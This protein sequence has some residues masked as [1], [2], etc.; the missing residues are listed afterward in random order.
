MALTSQFKVGAPL[1]A[2]RRNW[3]P[4][5]RLDFGESGLV[6]LD[7]WSGACRHETMAVMRSTFELALAEE[8]EVPFVLYRAGGHPWSD[9]DYSYH[10]A[11]A[12]G[13]PD[14]AADGALAVT[15][16]VVEA[17]SGIVKAVREETC[18][19]ELAEALR[20][21][22]ARDAGRR[23]AER[24]RGEAVGRVHR[25]FP[26][27]EA[28]VAAASIRRVFEPGVGEDEVLETTGRAC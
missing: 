2:G 21:M 24:E 17:S 19:A 20:A 26:T 25:R 8:D 12:S 16:V 6:I 1:V 9:V 3:S 5:N 4:H 13:R 27:P 22:A 28:L 18:D 23:Y 14:L 15:L 10:R 7:F 11:E